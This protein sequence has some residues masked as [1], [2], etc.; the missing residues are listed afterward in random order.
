MASQSIG[1]DLDETF[2]KFLGTLDKIDTQLD[3][4]TDSLKQLRKV[5]HRRIN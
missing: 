2:K 4:I 5:F 1:V 3:E